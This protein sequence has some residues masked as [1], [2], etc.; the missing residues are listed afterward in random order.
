[1]TNRSMGRSCRLLGALRMT[2]RVCTRSYTL[3]LEWYTLRQW[4]N[5]SLSKS[6]SRRLSALCSFLTLADRVRA[7]EATELAEELSDM[8]SRSVLLML[9]VRRERGA[10]LERVREQTLRAGGAALDLR[11]A[12]RLQSSYIHAVRLWQ[13]IHL[14]LEICWTERWNGQLQRAIKS[15]KL[16]STYHALD[17]SDR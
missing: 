2:L 5:C 15:N 10:T 13:S 8:R 17:I 7:L 11:L 3:R 16:I 14:L 1:M 9:A 12:S 6:L 4:I